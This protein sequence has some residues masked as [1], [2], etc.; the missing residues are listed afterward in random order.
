[1]SMATL[2]IRDDNGQTVLELRYLTDSMATTAFE[3][4]LEAIELSTEQQQTGGPRAPLI[5]LRSDNK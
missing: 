5:H 1:M 3:K 4:I 2:A